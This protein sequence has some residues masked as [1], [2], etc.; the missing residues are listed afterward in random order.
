MT[1]ENTSLEISNDSS[2]DELVSK[3]KGPKKE[4]KSKMQQKIL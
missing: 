3:G 1:E 4:V 2:R